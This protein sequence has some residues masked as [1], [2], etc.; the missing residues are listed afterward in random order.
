MRG[1]PGLIACLIACFVAAPRIL[2]LCG[3]LAAA[4]RGPRCMPAACP[5]CALRQRARW[6]QLHS[7]AVGS[8]FRP[9]R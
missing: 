8:P 3:R 1:F 7:T 2:L 9:G 6:A 5:L 4:L